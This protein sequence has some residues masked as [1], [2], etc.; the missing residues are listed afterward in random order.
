M[1]IRLVVPLC[2]SFSSHNYNAFI[3]LHGPPAM[4]SSDVVPALPSNAVTESNRVTL[5]RLNHDLKW[6]SEDFL[7]AGDSYRL[8]GHDEFD[9]PFWGYC[10]ETA[11]RNETREI[12]VLMRSTDE[13]TQASILRWWPM[14][15]FY[16][17]KHA[18]LLH[19]VIDVNG[20]AEDVLIE[21]LQLLREVFEYAVE[22]DWSYE[23]RMEFYHAFPFDELTT[24]ESV[25]AFRPELFGCPAFTGRDG[26]RLPAA[27]E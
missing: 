24:K 6:I 4:F 19:K 18:H 26:G 25:R 3:R 1:R 10:L 13:M 20:P 5:D 8:Y 7:A 12:F 21:I 16:T 14:E 2:L 17:R 22:D 11:C 27:A 15:R 9:R 23:K